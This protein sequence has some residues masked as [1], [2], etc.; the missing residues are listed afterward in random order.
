MDG[1]MGKSLRIDLATGAVSKNDIDPLLLNSYLGGRG[2]GVRTLFDEVPPDIDPLSPGNKLIFATGPLTGTKA[3][4]SGRSSLVTRS[5]LTGTIF[6]SNCGG[7]FGPR[8]KSCGYD[9]LIVEGSSPEPTLMVIRDDQVELVRCPELWGKGVSETISELVLRYG[10]KYSVACIGP[11]GENLARIASIMVDNHR[12]FGRGGVGAVMGSKNL[13]AIVVSGSQS[14]NVAD[15]KQLDFVVYECNKWLKGNPITSQGLPEF[16]TPVLLNLLN[17][18]GA[19]PVRNHQECQASYAEA[20]SGER[21]AETIFVKRSGCSHCPIQCGRETRTARASG[22]GPEYESLWALG[23]QCGVDNLEDIAEA[24]YLCNDLGLD[25]ISTG[26][27]IS[28]AMELSARGIIKESISF[29]DGEAVKELV[30]KIAR[31]EGIGDELAE[32]SRRFAGRHGAEEFAMQSKGLEFPAYDPRGM[33]GMGLAYATSNRG[34][35]HLRAYMVGPEVLGIPKLIDRFSFRGKSG[36]TIYFQNSH[37]AMDSLVLCRF[38]GLALSDEYFARLLSAVIG[39][40]VEPQDLQITGERIWNLERLY[41][42]RA[43]FRRADDSLPPR[44]TSEPVPSGPCKG[45]TVE[46][47]EMLQ[48]YY[49]SRGWD[50]DGVPSP[51]KLRQLGL[52]GELIA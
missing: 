14:V 39:R 38:A 25:T 9:M 46:L 42:I 40:K 10:Q 12:A 34:G 43:G 17:T 27:T 3:P 8:L 35:C 45:S 19:L 15:E 20:V 32:G 7:W 49:R 31:R 29:G 36:L 50:Q 41:N 30:V 51:A 6:D 33:K 44:L 24:N 37:A 5:P 26:S 2:L 13:K 16:G 1:W 28:C 4:T 47:D 48:E 11:A 23:P 22:K 18:I 21:I 52:E